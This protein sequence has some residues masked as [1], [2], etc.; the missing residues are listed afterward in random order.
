MR[1]SICWRRR[2]RSAATSSEPAVTVVSPAAGARASQRGV[3]DARAGVLRSTRCDGR[4]RGA[5]SCGEGGGRREA[6]IGS[7]GAQE[8][9]FEQRDEEQEATDQPPC[10]VDM[11]GAVHAERQRSEYRHRDA[12][13]DDGA[14]SVGCDQQTDSSPVEIR[15]HP[16]GGDA[17]S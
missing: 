8:E 9:E 10:S 11:H 5:R 3:R 4:R 12:V 1:D 13:K 17:I 15:L 16:A 7:R 2:K 6:R 14:R